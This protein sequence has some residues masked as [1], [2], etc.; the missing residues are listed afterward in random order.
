MP[1]RRV[2]PAGL[3]KYLRHLLYAL[4]FCCGAGVNVPVGGAASPKLWFSSMD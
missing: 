4:R 2:R 1:V 3:H